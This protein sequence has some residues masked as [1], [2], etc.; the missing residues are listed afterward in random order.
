M[1]TGKVPS[2]NGQCKS[3]QAHMG[4][5]MVLGHICAREG[6]PGTYWHRKGPQSSISTGRVHGQ[7]METGMEHGT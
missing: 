2:N 1:G 6:C 5:G 7:K 3:A 4:T